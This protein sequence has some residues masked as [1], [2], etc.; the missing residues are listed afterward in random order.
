MKLLTKEEARRR[1]LRVQQ[2]GQLQKRPSRMEAN[3]SRIRKIPDV[4]WYLV[5]FLIERLDKIRIRNAFAD[6][7]RAQAARLLA[8]QDGPPFDRHRG[9]MTLPYEGGNAAIGR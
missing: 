8:Q 5:Q 4:Q 2:K 7:R 6:A 9:R 3:M 1:Y